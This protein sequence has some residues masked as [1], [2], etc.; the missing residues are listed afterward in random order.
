[1]SF[2][3]K[4]V[5]TVERVSKKGAPTD[6]D[7][8]RNKNH[9]QREVSLFDEHLR[10]LREAKNDVERGGIRVE[11]GVFCF[12]IPSGATFR[13]GQNG[14]TY[15]KGEQTVEVCGPLVVLGETR[16]EANEARQL[17]ICFKDSDGVEHERTIGYPRVHKP[18]ELVTELNACGLEIRYEINA[19]GGYARH[20][21]NF[22]L[23]FPKKEPILSVEHYGWIGEPGTAF[24][25]PNGKVLGRA[26]RPVCFSG[27]PEDAPAFTQKG[28]LQ[29]WQDDVASRGLYSSRIALALCVGFAPVLMPFDDTVEN[30]G[31]HFFGKSSAGKS[32][33]ARALCSVWSSADVTSPEM[34]SW[35]NTDNG[36][37]GRAASHHYFP[38]VLDE[39][40]QVKADLL[41][42]IIYM[43]M[44]G[45]GKGRMSKTLRQCG[46]KRWR[47]MFLSTGERTTVEHA[48]TSWRKS[49]VQEGAL[50]R[51]LNIPALAGVQDYGVFETLP[52]GETPE[53]AANR[54]N[55]AAKVGSYGVAGPEFVKRLTKHIAEHG[56]VDEFVKHLQDLAN[57]WVAER[58]GVK[59]SQVLRAA[60][61]FGFAAAAGELAIEL[62]I[63]PWPRETASQQVARCFDAWRE[64]FKTS[65]ERLAELCNLFDDFIAQNCDRFDFLDPSLKRGT[66][67]WSAHFAN[68]PKGPGELWG[69]IIEKNGGREV[70]L[71]PG[72][73]AKTVC[74]KCGC[75]RR[76]ME[77]ALE[78]AQ[79][80]M[81]NNGKQEKIWKVREGQVIDGRVPM[82][83]AVRVRSARS[84][85]EASPTISV[86][87]E[88]VF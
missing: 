70:F 55:T 5:D 67:E 68:R 63:L 69:Y 86:E 45:T 58:K 27:S 7:G 14:V 40:T 17:W 53:E 32:T 65:E 20:V 81:S 38:M 87:E 77:D 88:E 52:S 85:G 15:S 50:L 80:L 47:T 82:T 66:A 79:R 59:D 72:V 8:A 23:Q 34:S 60:K 19:Q 78:N 37:E 26:S 18:N 74:P 75:T 61:S 64:G 71:I 39:I 42:D 33:A 4:I 12:D 10:K 49:E 84:T 21:A 36:L 2:A 41:V 6:E 3:K 73:F 83:R 22:L 62:K 28:T 31:F 51:M 56:D 57:H 16:S 13:F 24:F 25:L 44:N 43:L 29:E 35:R 1:M 30:A 48:S 76:D 11:D 46:T 54:L 9:S